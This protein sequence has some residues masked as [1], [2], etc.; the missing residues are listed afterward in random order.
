MKDYSDRTNSPTKKE[1]EMNE[2]YKKSVRVPCPHCKQ[3]MK[4]EI[5]VP[6]PKLGIEFFV[7]NN[8][9]NTADLT[10]VYHRPIK[11][12]DVGTMV[13]EHMPKG[14]VD[15]L[16]VGLGQQHHADNTTLEVHETNKLTKSIHN[17][18]HT[19]RL[20]GALKDDSFDVVKR[21]RRQDK[22]LWER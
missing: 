22:E 21:L 7:V 6:V 5:D 1:I 14:V 9:D 20:T 3:S 16:I 18:R 15:K 19:L 4:T 17:R 11:K 13:Y 12:A 2:T 8:T 10:V